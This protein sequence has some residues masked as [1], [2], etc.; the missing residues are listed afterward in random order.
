M[1]LLAPA[2][3]APRLLWQPRGSGASG[4]LTPSAR[5][6]LCFPG[7]LVRY[8]FRLPPPAP[9]ER[10][11]GTYAIRTDAWRGPWI[12]LA[13]DPPAGETWR[14]LLLSDH[15]QLPGTAATMRAVRNHLA[16]TPCQGILFPGDCVAW[17]DERTHWC[18]HPQQLGFFDSLG[19]PG[20]AGATRLTAA[21]SPLSA[22]PIWAAP[23]NH[24]VSGP[25]A[26]GSAAERFERVAPGRWQIETFHRLLL[27]DG[28]PPWYRVRVGPLDLISLF[29]ARRYARGDHAA[30]RGPCYEPPGRFIFA[31]ITP[32]AEQHTWLCSQVSERPDEEACGARSGGEP[33]A[34]RDAGLRVVQLHHPPYAQGINAWPPF[35]EPVAY[36]E[37]EIIA[38]LV[39][40]IAPWADLVCGGHNHAVNHHRIDGV[41]YFESSHIGCGHPPYERLSNG[42]PA[43]EPDGHPSA[44]FRTSPAT[45]FFSELEVPAAAR[46]ARAIVRTWEVEPD[47]E[48]RLAYRFT[49]RA[50]GGA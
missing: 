43:P 31:P 14:F 33:R 24:D 42:E 29:V 3:A 18:G 16:H 15:Q 1:R 10:W 22:L 45:T 4:E 19:A 46:S 5:G 34:V 32:G 39:P 27:A 9:G 36:R 2:A 6:A 21:Q 44:F 8:S 23:G 12:R 38:H 40:V 35:G 50:T 28:A 20:W 48:V 11:G 7:D 49:C 30:R 47:G 41:D 25:P 37:H 26:R 13:D 17:P